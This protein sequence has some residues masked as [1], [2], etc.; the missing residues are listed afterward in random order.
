MLKTKR[1]T[2]Y[3]LMLFFIATIGLSGCFEEDDGDCRIRSTN[4]QGC[5]DATNENGYCDRAREAGETC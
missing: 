2:T 4:G 1:A 5:F 3:K